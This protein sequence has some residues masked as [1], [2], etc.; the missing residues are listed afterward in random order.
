MKFVINQNDKITDEVAMLTAEKKQNR[1]CRNN[2][3]NL[4][5]F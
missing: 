4:I 5:F 1:Y 2:F 3:I